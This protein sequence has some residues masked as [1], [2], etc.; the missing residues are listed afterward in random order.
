M[1]NCCIY[2]N[3]K[4]KVRTVTYNLL[5]VQQTFNA[6]KQEHHFKWPLQKKDRQNYSKAF[7]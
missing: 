5:D 3:K 4:M 7:P 2:T 1:N 6:F